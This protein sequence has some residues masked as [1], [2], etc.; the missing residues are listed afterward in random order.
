MITDS[1][2]NIRTLTQDQPR[3]S[4]GGWL[5]F[6][7][8]CEVR[9]WEYGVIYFGLSNCNYILFPDGTLI[10]NF[11]F[12]GD[13]LMKAVAENGWEPVLK[14]IKDCHRKMEAAIAVLKAI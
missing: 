1:E 6:L 8:T 4:Y 3:G 13:T 7:K 9:R 5:G 12:H 2:F 11:G 14:Q 10:K